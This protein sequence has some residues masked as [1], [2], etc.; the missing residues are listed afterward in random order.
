M[1]LRRDGTKFQYNIKNSY[2]GAT[3][4]CNIITDRLC[5]HWLLIVQEP[6]LYMNN[7][8]LQ[9]ESCL[10]QPFDAVHSR[11]V[12]PP[13]KDK[14]FSCPHRAILSSDYIHLKNRSLGKIRF[15]KTLICFESY[16][17]QRCFF[18]CSISILA[19]HPESLTLIGH[20]LFWLL[21]GRRWPIEMSC[22]VTFACAVWPSWN[23]FGIDCE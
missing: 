7:R 1:V 17:V 19:L 23:T 21:F 11:F 4:R 13:E 8:K 10:V 15:L 18:F 20:C 5:F 9:R 12:V 22:Q 16:P 2:F 3:I 14:T 6:A